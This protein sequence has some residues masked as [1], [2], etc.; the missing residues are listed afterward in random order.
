MALPPYLMTMVLPANFWMYGSA[1]MS[2]DAL[3]AALM[4]VCAATSSGVLTVAILKAF[5]SLIIG[6]SFLSVSG[7]IFAVDFHVVVGEV[8]GPNSGVRITFVEFNGDRN[9]VF[10]HDLFKR[11]FVIHSA[12][13]VFKNSNTADF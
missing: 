11:C 2:M 13:A 6:G 7:M 4:V 1:S 5:N 8:A 12:H 9:I 10:V 3:P